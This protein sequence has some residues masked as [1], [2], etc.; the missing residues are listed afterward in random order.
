[1]KQHKLSKYRTD[2]SNLGIP[3]LPRFQLDNHYMYNMNKVMW[4]NVKKEESCVTTETEQAP[5]LP[6]IP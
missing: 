5:H 1:M 6:Y 4:N 2:Y 3:K